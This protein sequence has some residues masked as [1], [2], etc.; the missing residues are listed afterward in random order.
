M[1]LE[2]ISVNFWNIVISLLNLTIMFLILKKLLFKPVQNIIAKRQSSVDLQ[3]E[4]AANA[5]KIANENRAKWE[6]TLKGAGN[7]ADSIIKTAQE[8]ATRRGDEIVAEARE[9]AQGIIRQ[10]QSEAEMEKRKAA[11]EIKKEIADVSTLL[12]ERMLEREINADDHRKLIDSFINEIGDNN[13]GN[14]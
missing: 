10:A 6:E 4:N 13:D 12:S 7:E 14:K 2:V 9:K 11:E 8:N 1:N 5:E 3:Y